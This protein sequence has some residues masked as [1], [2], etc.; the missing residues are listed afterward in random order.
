MLSRAASLKSFL[1][2]G[3]QLIDGVSK[4]T[5]VVPER[6][7]DAARSIVATLLQRSTSRQRN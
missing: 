6:I 1:I 7:S 4:L 5:S 3:G 2:Q